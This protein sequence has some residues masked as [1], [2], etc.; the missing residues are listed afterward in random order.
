MV[1]VL[2][3][4]GGARGGAHDPHVFQRPFR[5]QGDLG[6]GALGGGRQADLDLVGERLHPAH[7]T[8]RLLRR[9]F[10]GVHTIR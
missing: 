7:P 1:K 9:P 8:G 10:L 2:A 3:D 4:R 5:R 6:V